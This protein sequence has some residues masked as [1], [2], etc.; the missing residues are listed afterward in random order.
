MVILSFSLTIKVHLLRWS[1][2]QLFVSG[3][4]GVVGSLVFEGVGL[5]G[6][7]AGLPGL[8][9]IGPTGFDLGLP[10]FLHHRVEPHRGLGIL[11]LEREREREG[12]NAYTRGRQ[13]AAPEPHAAL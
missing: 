6:R 9:L 11:H 5:E 2:D 10:V 4:R 7:G 3:V 1:R 8:G 12:M 13:P